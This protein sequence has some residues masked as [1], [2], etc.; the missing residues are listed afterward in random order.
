ME[1][2]SVYSLFLFGLVYVATRAI[3]RL[4]FHPLSHFPGPIAAHLTFWT[5]FY[6]DAICRGQ[7]IWKLEEWHRKYGPIIRISPEELH[8]SDPTFYDTVYPG[9]SANRRI[10]RTPRQA[11]IFGQ[12][13]SG[14]GTP[15]HELHRARRASLAPAF[16]RRA[17][18]ELQPLIVEK[19]RY[20]MKRFQDFKGAGRPIELFAAFSALTGDIISQ[21]SFGSDAAMDLLSEDNFAPDWHR[22][23]A[24]YAAMGAMG[25]MFWWFWPVMN[26]FPPRVMETMQPAMKRMMGLKKMVVKR[27]AEILEIREGNIISDVPPTQKQRTIFH[28]I[29]ESDIPEEEKRIQRLADEADVVMA[30]GTGTTAETLAV[31]CFHI[32]NDPDILERLT[33]EI[34]PVTQ[35]GQLRW[36][37]LEQLPYLTAVIK[38]G[39]R[40]CPGV[41]AR[42]PRVQPDNA[43]KYKDWTIP[44]GTAV[45]MSAWEV[46]QDAT[47]FPSPKTFNPDRWLQSGT[48][49]VEMERYLVSFSKGTRQCLGIELAKAEMY[50]TLAAL[51][52]AHDVKIELFET[53]ARDV[54]VVGDI[55]NPD[56]PKESKGVRVVVV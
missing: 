5:E 37:D 31:M 18:V 41:T 9:S 25:K 32:L 7:Y 29:V 42:L 15:G 1:L 10:E 33:K 55:F 45:S 2:F 54:Q 39:L 56:F 52:G 21:Y 27:V 51:F 4:Y 17:V 13:G 53:T 47:I 22:L 12:A 6:Y 23:I 34:Q 28:E 35:N 3:Y 43:I 36:Q 44:P 40:I 24:D 20:L 48:E 49:R 14:F 16:G 38:E 30:A 46:H 19:V 26:S 11:G 8:V 50:L